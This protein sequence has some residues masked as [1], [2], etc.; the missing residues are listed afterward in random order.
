MY[1][2]TFCEI[3]AVGNTPEVLNPLK[4]HP[5][6]CARLSASQPGGLTED[7]PLILPSFAVLRKYCE[8]TYC[9]SYMS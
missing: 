4:L 5:L 3:G 8:I 9:V 7:L 1:L 2:A 6:Y